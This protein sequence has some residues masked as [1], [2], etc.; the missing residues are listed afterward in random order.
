MLKAKKGVN[1]SAIQYE[2]GGGQS[3]ANPSLLIPELDAV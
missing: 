3:I 1:G 2:G